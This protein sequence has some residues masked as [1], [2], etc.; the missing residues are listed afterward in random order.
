[1]MMVQAMDQVD[2]RYRKAAEFLAHHP[3]IM[4]GYIILGGTEKNEGAIITRNA[5]IG[6]ARDTDIFTLDDRRMAPPSL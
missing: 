4:P 2:G 6:S 5:S 3:L 1:M